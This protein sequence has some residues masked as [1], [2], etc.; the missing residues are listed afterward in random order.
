MKPVLVIFA[1]DP[2]PGRVK[3][4]L[5]AGIGP[6]GAAA[7]YRRAVTGLVRKVGRDPRW[8]TVLA[9][10]PDRAGLMSPLLPGGVP[11]WAQGAGDLGDRMG[12]ALAAFGPGPVVIIGSD[13]PGVTRAAVAGAFAAL[14]GHDA[15]LGPA[16]DGG[17]WLIGLRRGGQ[18]PRGLFTDVRWS[19]PYA[20]ADTV[21]GLVGRRIAEAATLSDVDTVADLRPA[22]I[23]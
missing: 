15:V 21:A 9:V 16:A 10:A 6:V 2:L 22:D 12:R 18:V 13:I 23:R 14:R 19:G 4:R 1:K 5:A 20:M 11:R 8:E 17:Y 7:W 3:T